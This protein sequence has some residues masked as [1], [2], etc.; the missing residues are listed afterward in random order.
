MPRPTLVV[1]DAHDWPEVCEIPIY[2][3]M[4]S[5]PGKLG[6]SP[7][8]APW[9]DEYLD[10]LRPHLGRPAAANVAATLGDPPD[11][12]AVADLIITREATHLFHEIHP[13]TFA[14][15]FPSTWVMELLPTSACTA[16]SP[17]MNP[18]SSPC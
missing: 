12:T 1:A 11:F 2:G 8:P 13:V 18:T 6:T 16:T 15:E 10:T 5:V 17:P 9:W 4:F 7:T 14:S 3:M